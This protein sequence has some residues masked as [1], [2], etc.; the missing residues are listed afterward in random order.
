MTKDRISQ[1][2]DLPDFPWIVVDV[3]ILPISFL[4]SKIRLYTSNDD[5]RSNII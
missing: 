1:D 5:V 2:N 3:H 4:G